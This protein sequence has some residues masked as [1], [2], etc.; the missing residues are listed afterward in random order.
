M[1]LTRPPRITDRHGF[2][3]GMPRLDRIEM[4]AANHSDAAVNALIRAAYTMRVGE[5]RLD[6]IEALSLRLLASAV[7]T[8]RY[9]GMEWDNGA[10]TCSG[11]WDIDL[12]EVDEHTAL[13]ASTWVSN[14]QRVDRFRRQPDD[15]I[16]ELAAFTVDLHEFRSWAVGYTWSGGAAQDNRTLEPDL[17]RLAQA[18]TRALIPGHLGSAPT[19]TAWEVAAAVGIS[20]A[21]ATADGPVSVRR[22]RAVMRRHLLAEMREQVA[23]LNQQPPHSPVAP[24]DS[25]PYPRQEVS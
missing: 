20:P 7:P 12:T 22:L 24:G 17:L 15:A 23:Q 5:A 8:A 1:N 6:I 18:A 16:A 2:S 13:E 9:I 11:A 10:W 4:V 3:L 14:I 21:L 19:V 25:C